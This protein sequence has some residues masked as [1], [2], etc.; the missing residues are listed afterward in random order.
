MLRLSLGP[1]GIGF[2]IRKMGELRNQLAREKPTRL[3]FYRACPAPCPCPACL[4][5]HP[6]PRART[7]RLRQRRLLWL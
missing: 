4:Q 7:P 5:P 2:N 1:S 3:R 6:A